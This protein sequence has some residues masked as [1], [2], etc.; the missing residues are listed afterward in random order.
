[1]SDWE[2]VDASLSGAAAVGG[3]AA[4]G[5]G[6]GDGFPGSWGGTSAGGGGGSSAPAV[7]H[8]SSSTDDDSGNDGDWGASGGGGG[9]GDWEVIGAG[10]AVAAPA[11]SDSFGGSDDWG[12]AT[13]AP[14]ASDGFGDDG[15]GDDVFGSTADA[16][17]GAQLGGGGGGDDEFGCS[18]GVD[19]FA[20]APTAA[21]QSAPAVAEMFAGGGDWAQRGEHRPGPVPAAAASALAP[22]SA[23][24]FGR[25]WETASS[26]PSS[27]APATAVAASV[28]DFMSFAPLA[29]AP[30]EQRFAPPL[31]PQFQQQ[32]SADLN[33]FG[34]AAPTAA[35]TAT[36]GKPATSSDIMGLFGAMS[37]GAGASAFRFS[38]APAWRRQRSTMRARA[39]PPLA[40]ASSL[41]R[42][43]ATAV[44]SAAAAAGAP[45][46]P[47]SAR[48]TSLAPTSQTSSLDSLISAQ[49]GKI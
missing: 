26:E 11:A 9:G 25:G 12:A 10:S 2:V 39:H 14:A 3:R 5:G 38:C 18:N 42:L 49:L 22:A 33:L 35:P 36:P 43:P 20:S 7:V 40:A 45:A 27:P 19:L 21:P 41:R 24:L 31:Q 46:R 29:E 15:F 1:M 16:G 47:S 28:E 48:L 6:D 44:V 8:T 17:F 4:V 13:E 32:P 30:A 34:M 23:D 37:V